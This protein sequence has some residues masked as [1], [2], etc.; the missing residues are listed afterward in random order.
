MRIESILIELADLVRKIENL[1][2]LL[3]ERTTASLD[4]DDRAYI[5]AMLTRLETKKADLEEQFR[6]MA[7]PH[8]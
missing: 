5:D 8:S 1:R 6:A 7:K 3:D 2:S 4:S